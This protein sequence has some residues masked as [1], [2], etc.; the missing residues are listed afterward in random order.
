MLDQV[1]DALRESAGRVFGSL[2]SILPS[3]MALMASVFIAG[4]LGWLMSALLVRTLR[5]VRFDDQLE[6]IGFETVGEWAPQRS[7]TLLMGRLLFWMALLFG[8]LVG[9]AALDPA[10]MNT[11]AARLMTY[12]PNVFVAGLLV[13]GGTVLARYLARSVLIGGVNMQLQAARLLSVGVKWMVLVLTAT[14]ALSQ[15]GI[16]GT[17]LT[18]AFGILFGGIVLALSLA[19]GLASKDIV[20]RTLERQAEKRPDAAESPV[21]HL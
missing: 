21:H 14:M 20:S 12:L 11:L 6:R 2:V 9:L 15:L 17:I 18:L 1:N 19:V 4:V 7:P 8:V 13:V 16:G 5:W 3:M 10:L